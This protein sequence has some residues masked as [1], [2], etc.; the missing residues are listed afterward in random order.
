MRKR[1]EPLQW[2]KKRKKIANAF[3]IKLKWK[4][5]WNLLLRC[6]TFDTKNKIHK[7][8]RNAQ[9]CR[10]SLFMVIKKRNQRE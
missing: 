10:F 9:V 4:L 1:K 8:T 5:K 6:T 2:K 3:E 7:F